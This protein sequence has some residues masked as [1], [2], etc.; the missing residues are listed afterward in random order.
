MILFNYGALFQY[1]QISQVCDCPSQ[2]KAMRTLLNV[3]NFFDKIIQLVRSTVVLQY[4]RVLSN[5]LSL[6][7]LSVASH[8][9]LSCYHQPTKPWDW[10]PFK[11][12]HKQ[13]LP[14]KPLALRFTISRFATSSFRHSS[15]KITSRTHCW[16][17]I[18][19][20]LFFLKPQTCPPINDLRV[21][22]I[23]A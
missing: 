5:L 21:Y 19:L 18:C 4:V 9:L 16:E 12:F 15:A 8:R 3:T 7:E 17:I 14:K 11:Q 1:K 10:N 22:K 6:Y 20:S 13:R 2:K 23:T